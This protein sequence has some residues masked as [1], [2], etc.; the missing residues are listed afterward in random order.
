MPKQGEG[1]LALRALNACC[2]QQQL[3]DDDCI[4]DAACT[5]SCQWIQS[6][7][8]NT[9]QSV[10]SI[11]VTSTVE[12]EH[13][14][15]VVPREL[16]CALGR[17]ILQSA[18]HQIS[19]KQSNGN[20]ALLYITLPLLEGDG[21]QKLY[22][23][24]LTNLDWNGGVMKLFSSLEPQNE[25][26]EVVDMVDHEGIVLGSLPRTY[27]HKWNILHRG[28]GMI[29][30]KDEDVFKSIQDRKVPEVY[31]HQRTSTKRIFPSLYDMFVGGVS[32]RG[33]QIER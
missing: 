9:D 6:S 7:D 12:K 25:H 27:V 21:C 33:E 11:N 31:V 17:I 15:V 20:D 1:T 14:G 10:W 30:C 23:T 18:A 2:A 26:L 32:C 8:D 28:I 16:L 4:G 3:N 13:D 24:D 19:S 5:L 22:L 29:V